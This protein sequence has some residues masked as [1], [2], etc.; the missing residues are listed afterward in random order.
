MNRSRNILNKLSSGTAD[1]EEPAG[2][3]GCHQ[4]S[5]LP[6]QVIDMFDELIFHRKPI[7]VSRFLHRSTDTDL[8]QIVTR[9]C[10]SRFES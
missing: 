1:A 6:T 5:G 3:C 10:E 4:I 8:R 9:I 2:V 7:L